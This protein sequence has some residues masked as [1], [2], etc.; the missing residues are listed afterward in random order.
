MKLFKDLPSLNWDNFEETSQITINICKEMANKKI[1]TQAIRKVETDP[2]LFDLCE[3]HELDD[4]I[5]IYNNLEKGYRIRLR[6]GNGDQYERAHNHRFP[7]TTLILHGTYYQAWYGVKGQFNKNTKLKDITKLCARVEGKG[8]YFSIS[9]SAVHST[10]TDLNTISLV[11]C[12]PPKK[13][14]TNIIH[15]ET[16]EAWSKWGKKFETKDQIKKAKMSKER[17]LFWKKKLIEYDL[18]DAS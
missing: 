15:M 6:L 8:A 2:E 18:I 11:I 13:D 9:D 3:E 16:G 1:L 5:V 4:K 17:F 7:F 12:G 14:K 10:Q